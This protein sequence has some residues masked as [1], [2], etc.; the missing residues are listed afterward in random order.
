MRRQPPEEELDDD[1]DI[2]ELVLP[3]EAGASGD[4]VADHSGDAA[5][6]AETWQPVRMMVVPEMPEECGWTCF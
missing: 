1:F 5:P 3:S 6:A 4:A 2:D